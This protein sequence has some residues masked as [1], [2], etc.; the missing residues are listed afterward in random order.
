MTYNFA[1][2][3][4]LDGDVFGFFYVLRCLGTI[5]GVQLTIHLHEIARSCQ[6]IMRF[7]SFPQLDLEQCL[8]YRSSLTGERLNIYML[9][10]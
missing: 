5:I 1:K 10:E 2:F 7:P 6:M 9:V 4:V 8:S 3:S